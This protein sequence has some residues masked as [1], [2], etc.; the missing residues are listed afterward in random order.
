M[1]N[2][3]PA[4]LT[5]TAEALAK[6][7]EIRAVEDDPDGMG[8]RVEIVGTQGNEFVYDLSLEELSSTAPDDV[9]WED[10]GL[11]RIVPGNTVEQLR[12]A[13]LDV[14]ANPQQGGLVIRN[15][16][17][18]GLLAGDLPELSGTVDERINQL[19]EGHVN[20]GLAA[21]GGHA[22]LDRVEGSVAYVLMGGGC[23]GCALSA[24]TLRDGISAAIREAIPEIDEVVDV[25][26][27]DEGENPF[28]SEDPTPG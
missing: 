5:V 28:Y 25:T 3:D 19:L 9:V 21:H 13:V 12:G 17:T 1:S 16:N 8:L 26:A 11:T 2:A 4:V 20:P 14:P 24:V 10:E 18:P 7:L 22:A 27:H 6:V 23:Q 15:P